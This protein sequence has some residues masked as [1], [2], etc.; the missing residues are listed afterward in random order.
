MS[1]FCFMRFHSFSPNPLGLRISLSS[2]N[3]GRLTSSEGL[4]YVKDPIISVYDN[5]QAIRELRDKA[6]KTGK[7]SNEERRNIASILVHLTE[8]E[9]E[10][11]EI[12]K[13]CTG[14]SGK[15]NYNTDMTQKQIK[16]IKNYLK[17]VTCAQLCG[18][19][20][21]RQRAKGGRPIASSYAPNQ[22]AKLVIDNK[23]N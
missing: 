10:I 19:D 21:I 2:N 15:G 3:S 14:Y 11:H 7:L 20:N 5:C 18:C 16:N 6:I 22:S 1:W 17:P 23:E 4:N 8:G 13:H 9:H 12:M